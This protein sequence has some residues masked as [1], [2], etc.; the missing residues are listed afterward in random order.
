[1]KKYLA[2]FL[3]TILFCNT[4]PAFCSNDTKTIRQK[5]TVSKTKDTHKNKTR[6]RNKKEQQSDYKAEYMNLQWWN[7]FNDPVLTDY[8]VKTA[9]SNYDIK[10]NALKVLEGN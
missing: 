7:R 4:L 6:K 1:M 3:I 10:I 5:A 2:V 9:D 8:I